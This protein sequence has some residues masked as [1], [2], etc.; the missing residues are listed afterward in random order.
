MKKNWLLLGLML[1]ATLIACDSGSDSK[2]SKKDEDKSMPS[3][4]IGEVSDEP[5]LLRYKFTPGE[6]VNYD[7]TMLMEMDLGGYGEMEMDMAF[8]GYY[9]VD[10]VYP[11]G[12]ALVMMYIKKVKFDISGMPGMEVNYDSDKKSDRSNQ[13]YY[14]MNEL[15]DEAVPTLVSSLGEVGDL[16]ANPHSRTFAAA[17]SLL[18]NE[19]FQNL[20]DGSFQQLSLDSIRTGEKYEGGQLKIGNSMNM[21][22]DFKGS[23]L[24]KA[25]SK[26]KKI[27]V[28][29]PIVELTGESIKDVD[30]DGEIIFNVERGNVDES[31]I[32][33]DFDMEMEG[34][35]FTS[36]VKLTYKSDS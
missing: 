10:T 33:A 31:Y 24:V 22:M 3:L 29:K 12:Y 30:M 13:E 11:D 25:V 20:I 19:Q 36:K 21:D 16:D 17:S 8:N 14:Q 28:L 32:K 9:D 4:E 15:L 1:V 26:D 6:R 34:Q 35:S 7:Y 18:N 2:S 27:A 23:Y 5:V